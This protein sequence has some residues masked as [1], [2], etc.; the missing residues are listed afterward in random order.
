MELI[1]SATRRSR[2]SEV[3]YIGLNLTYAG[4]L[5]ALVATFDPP[6]LAYALVALS[7]WRVLA[8]RPRFWFAN[9][10]AN[11][12]DAMVG[13]SIVTLLWLSNGHLDTQAILTAV[14]AVWLV[15]LKPRSKQRFMIL[16]ARL[17]LFISLTALFSVAY[18]MPLLL[19]VLLCW[20][21]G[22]A[23]ARHVL[24]SYNNESERTFLALIWSF[25]VAE[26]GWL[27]YHWT[28]AYGL[29]DDFKI[30]QI[31]IVTGII[32]FVV[33]KAYELYHHSNNGKI[34]MSVLRWPLIFAVLALLILLI[35]F[36]GL[37]PT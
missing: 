14:F 21:I 35:R 2:L 8:V 20:I 27:G 10:Q 36:N 25:I 34:D 4:L 9:V 13:I 12:I 37:N 28:V 22:Y 30:P 18:T 26:L 5:W 16:Q 33:S 24:S 3:V 1:K 7:K 29:S 31:A 23:T 6:V 19:V 17:A 32:G 15:V 11:L